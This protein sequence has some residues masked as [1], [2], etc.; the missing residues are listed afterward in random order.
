MVNV[1]SGGCRSAD[2]Q[3]SDYFRSF[4]EGESCSVPS[5]HMNRKE[6]EI[7]DREQLISIINRGKF[8]SIAMCRES[9][10]YLIT[11]NYGYDRERNALYF[12]CASKGLKLDFIRA[13][14]NVCATVIEDRGYKKGECDHA[15]RSVVLWGTMH[16]VEDLK[17][18]KRAIDILLDHLEEDPDRIRQKSLKSDDAYQEVG[19]LRLDIGEMTGKQGG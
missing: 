18:K 1:L 5:Y 6:K 4:D 19:I 10:P 12:H 14:P 2:K 3:T 17:E 16:L 13:N 15:F 7:S 9:E 11:M 8:A